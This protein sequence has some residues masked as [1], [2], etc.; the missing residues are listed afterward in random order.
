MC[1]IV[2]AVGTIRKPHRHSRLMR[3]AITC[4]FRY[5]SGI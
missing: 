4:P 5:Y 2:F 1:V 3:Y